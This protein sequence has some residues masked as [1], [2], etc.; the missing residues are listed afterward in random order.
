MGVVMMIL[1]LGALLA[2][3]AVIVLLRIA[4]RL[5]ILPQLPGSELP[6][7]PGEPLSL[8]ALSRR[9]HRSGGGCWQPPR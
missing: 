2:L 8:Q 5:D 6:S 1:G 4:A 3:L 7:E 9:T